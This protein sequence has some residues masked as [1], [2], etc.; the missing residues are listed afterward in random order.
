M[1]KAGV[2]RKERRE[3]IKDIKNISDTQDAITKPSTQDA[4]KESN[5]NLF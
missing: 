2:S 1:A 4:A 3:L 5:V